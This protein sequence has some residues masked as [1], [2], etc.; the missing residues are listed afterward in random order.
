MTA[1]TLAVGVDS[2][3][4]GDVTRQ[5]VVRGIHAERA[6]VGDN[7]PDHLI[8]RPPID[9]GHRGPR[10]SL[11]NHRKQF[12]VGVGVEGDGEVGSPGLLAAAGV[13]AMTASALRTIGAL[14]HELI[15][16]CRIRVLLRGDGASEAGCDE[17][18]E[19][20]NGDEA[21]SRG[22]S[23]RCHHSRRV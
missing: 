23:H 8:G 20:R 13:A 7:L 9:P 21:N 1:G 16:R 11:A 22:F 18:R 5:L 4:P 14:A 17:R 12:R 19:Q 3:P 2:L 6:E 10:Y 15:D